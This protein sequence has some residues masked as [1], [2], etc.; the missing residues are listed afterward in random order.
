MG[1]WI[2]PTLSQVLS[3]MQGMSRP[4]QSVAQRQLQAEHQWTGAI[5]A[6]EALLETV[7]GQES[8]LVLSGP[9]PILS[10]SKLV[11]R[12]KVWAFTADSSL[13]T[14]ASFFQL[15]P[16]TEIL[17]APSR[18]T[19]STLPL[20]PSDPIAA[21]HFCLVLTSK[22]SLVMVLGEDIDH[23]PGFWFS[24]DPEEVKRAWQV[25]RLRVV[26]LSQE[27]V[28]KLDAIVEEFPPVTPSFSLVSQ[29]SQTLLSYLPPMEAPRLL[30]APIPV[31]DSKEETEARSLDVELLT[32]IAHEVRTPL[33]TIRTLT[34]LLMKRKDMSA[35]ALK[36]LEVIDRECSDQIDRFGIIFRAVELETSDTKGMSLTATCLNQ[37][38]NHSIPRWQQQ[39]SQRGLVLNVILP[40]G[41]PSVISDPMML[42][43]ALTSLIERS[44]RS[45]PSG[46]KI[47]VEVSV[48]GDQLKLQVETQPDESYSEHQPLLQSLGEMLTFQPETGVLS[49]NLAVTK[50]LFQA[51]GGKLTVKERS[52]HHGE[53]FTLFLPL[54]VMEDDRF[55]PKIFV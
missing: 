33:T 10:H 35:D 3:F 36:R 4:S 32:A 17:E 30:Q 8:G 23:Q 24:F 41:L 43:Q 53:V 48:A 42:D 16:S 26:M 38:L 27:Q 9:F 13:Q 12:F 54:Q 22:F 44:A 37:V 1:E 28:Q 11:E 7:D 51:I 18:E 15:P 55:G 46:S 6:L 31:T 14:I 47:Q 40:E 50:N 5:A 45:L 49:L 29:F 34:R 2:L 39:A 52:A 20:L 21:E 19:S 25:L